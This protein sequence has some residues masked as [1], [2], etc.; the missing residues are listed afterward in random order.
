M[1][2]KDRDG[3]KEKDSS[4]FEYFKIFAHLRQEPIVLL[5]QTISR[6]FIYLFICIS[7]STRDHMMSI[8]F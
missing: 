2:E 5:L 1:S 8:F 4:S 7:G 3:E 6:K